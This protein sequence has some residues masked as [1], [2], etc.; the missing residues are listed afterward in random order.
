[1]FTDMAGYSALS[2]RDERLAIELLEEQRCVIRALLP[3]H[4]GREVEMVGDGFLIEFAS[5]V[6]AVRCGVLIQQ[7]LE[8][9]TPR[10]FFCTQ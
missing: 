10:D 7:A 4:D 9:G 2:Q 5:A 6:Q 3:R 1:M 8:N